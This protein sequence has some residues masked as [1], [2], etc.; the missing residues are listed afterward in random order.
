MEDAAPDLY[1]DLLKQINETHRAVII[2]QRGGAQGCL[3]D[4]ES[5]EN[6][7]NAMGILKLLSQ[8][9]E[10]MMSRQE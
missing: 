1:A 3:Q 9:E 10:G 6:V 5:Y 2:T 4:P 8:V 7:R